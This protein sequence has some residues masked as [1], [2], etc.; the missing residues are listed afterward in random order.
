MMDRGWVV[1]QIGRR[2]HYALARLLSADDSLK[3]LY[4]DLWCQQPPSRFLPEAVR[5][6]LQSRFHPGLPHQRVHAPNPCSWFADEAG[7]ALQTRF[8]GCWSGMMRRNQWFQR[9]AV[10]WLERRP[11][12]AGGH[13]LFA[14]SY[15]ARQ[16]FQWA[17]K[18]GWPTVLGQID[19]GPRHYEIVSEVARRHGLPL[20]TLPSEAYWRQWEMECRLADQIV[21]NSEW[22][23]ECL[24]AHGIQSEKLVVIPLAY[25][26]PPQLSRAPKMIPETFTR[27]R[28]LRVLHTGKLTAAKGMVEL[29]EAAKGLESEPVEWL[30]AGPCE[31]EWVTRKL[32]NYPQVRWLGNLPGGAMPGLYQKA[33]VLLL[34]THSDGFALVQLEALAHGLPVIASLN[35][36]RVVQSGVQG[37]SLAEVSAAAITRSVRGLLSEPRMLSRWTEH[38]RVPENCTGVSVMHELKSLAATLVKNGA[39]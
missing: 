36:G 11:W 10:R 2:E 35:C 1:M 23:R 9:Q 29:F 19:P 18:H 38:A 13:V 3:A 39:A 7:V 17:K 14:Y 34:P 16:P 24:I 15:A 12:T 37:E 21:V 30:L 25:D 6:R 27:E 32:A 20:P 31:E 26:V 28:P 22:S 5:Q 33:D 4:T 8:Q